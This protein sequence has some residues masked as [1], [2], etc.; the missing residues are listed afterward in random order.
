[1]SIRPLLVPCAV[2]PRMFSGLW[3]PFFWVLLWSLWSFH[4]HVCTTQRCGRFNTDHLCYLISSL[5]VFSCSLNHILSFFFVFFMEWDRWR[6]LRSPNTSDFIT[7]CLEVH[8]RIPSLSSW[9][10]W[11]NANKNPYLLYIVW[12]PECLYG[13]SG[14][15]ELIG[16]TSFNWAYVYK[17]LSSCPSY[18]YKN[19]WFSQEI[20]F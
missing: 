16:K 19:K 12:I 11:N 14:E 8:S 7:T 9:I 15:Y 20:F 1:M 3:F 13:F 4:L 2:E 5:L 18:T 17:M 6:L 10:W